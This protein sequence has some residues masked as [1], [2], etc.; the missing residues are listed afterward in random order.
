GLRGFVGREIG[1]EIINESV[2]I[3][4]IDDRSPLDRLVD[5]L[6]PCALAQ[7][8]LHYDVRVVALQA[9][10]ANLPLHRPRRQIGRLR[11]ELRGTGKSKQR[12]CSRPMPDRKVLEVI[13]LE[14]GSSPDQSHCR[15]IHLDSTRRMAAEFDPDCQWRGTSAYSPPPLELS[16]RSSTTAMRS[17]RALCLVA[18]AAK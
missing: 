1:A 10:G 12:D 11:P 17:G 2:A 3:S 9:G 5:F 7:P 13:T 4:G 14:H 18:P 8:L 16:N 6:C 15:D